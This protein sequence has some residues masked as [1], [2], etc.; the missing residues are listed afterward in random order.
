MFFSDQFSPDFSNRPDGH[1]MPTSQD[2]LKD[3]HQ[4]LKVIGIIILPS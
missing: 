2:F 1:E 4:E 3:S